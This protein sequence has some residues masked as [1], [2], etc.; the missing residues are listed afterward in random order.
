MQ[1]TAYIGIGS[2]LESP[3]G[4]CLKAVE[5]LDTH[6]KVTLVARSSLYQSEPFG[7]TDQDW[8]V[9]C[10]VQ[11]TTSLTPEELL[12]IC[13]SIEQAM[14]R[15]RAEKWGPRIIDLDILFYNDLI[16]KQA[17]LEIPHPGITERSFVLAP[18]NEITPDY[19]H[20]KHK[21]SIQT[22]LTKIPK[23]QQVNRLTSNR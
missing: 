20:P 3:A 1:H 10:V 2:N 18:M 11:I 22:L 21:Q 15:A 13:L 19:I 7:N 6:P 12:H 5:S 4:N 8:F 16:I 14:G 23:P 17:G 9:N